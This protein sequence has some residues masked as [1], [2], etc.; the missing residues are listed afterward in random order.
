MYFTIE[1][2]SQIYYVL[3]DA[4]NIMVYQHANIMDSLLLIGDLANIIVKWNRSDMNFP[5]SRHKVITETS[6][7]CN[8]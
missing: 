1:D 8:E 3:T 2:S 6:Y 4:A 5:V 7:S